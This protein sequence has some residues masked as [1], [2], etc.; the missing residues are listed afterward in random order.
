MNRF[1]AGLIE[2][3][4]DNIRS[5]AATITTVIEEQASGQGANA[6]LDVDGAKQVLRGI[7][8]PKDWRVRLHDRAGQVVADTDILDNSIQVGTLDPIL[9]DQPALPRHVVLRQK[10]NA[11]LSFVAGSARSTGFGGYYG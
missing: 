3:K 10:A 7:N 6:G 8:V 11:W 4:V 9:S 1:E 5:L 2:G